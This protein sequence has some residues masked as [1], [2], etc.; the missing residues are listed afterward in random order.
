[1]WNVPACPCW[2]IRDRVETAGGSPSP[3]IAAAP[4]SDFSDLG[5]IDCRIRQQPNSVRQRFVGPP[6]KH[7]V[8]PCLESKCR[9]RKNPTSVGGLGVCGCR[10]PFSHSGGV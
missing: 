8:Y 6:T 3:K 10:S 2:G 9:S 1:M 5:I 4:K 7:V